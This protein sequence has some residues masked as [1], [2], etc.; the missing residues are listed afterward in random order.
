VTAY[1]KNHNVGFTIPYTHNGDNRNYHPDFVALV[2]KNGIERHLILEVTGQKRPDKEAK[3]AAARNLG[4]PAVNNHEAFG[5]W[6]FLE[7][8]DPWNAGNDISAFLN[9][10]S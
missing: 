4:V 2:R 6:A 3:V 5:R 10:L 1:F 9:S 7:I 8:T